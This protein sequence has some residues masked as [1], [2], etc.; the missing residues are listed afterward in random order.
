MASVDLQEL[1]RLKSNSQNICQWIRDIVEVFVV[2][3]VV[4]NFDIDFLEADLLVKVLTAVIKGP[5]KS[6][7]G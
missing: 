6:I 3:E 2:T 4:Q 5:E 7:V 1:N